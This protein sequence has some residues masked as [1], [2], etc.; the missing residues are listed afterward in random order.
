MGIDGCVGVLSA[1]DFV[2]WAEKGEHA[3]K[4]TAEHPGCIHSPWQLPDVEELP[5]DEVRRY[6]TAD[7]VTA[8]TTT[9]IGELA[10]MMLDAHI[11]RVVIVDEDR[12]PVGIV[13]ATDIL[14]A[15]AEAA[16]RIAAV[17]T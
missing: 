12:H 3:A 15:V 2:A 11:H 10:R 16:R 1:T 14:A 9:P 13:S 7:P 4:R 17:E 8:T 5:V 6:M